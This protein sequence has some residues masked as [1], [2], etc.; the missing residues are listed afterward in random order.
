MVSAILTLVVIGAIL[1]CLLG[2][3]NQYL[4]VE[5]DHRVEEVLG[6]L[7]GVNCGGCGYPGC[8]GFANALVSKEA[9]SVSSCVVSNEEIKKNIQAYLDSQQ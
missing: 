9:G 2:I 3:A 8:E 6:M 5:E 1:G 7:P 4:A